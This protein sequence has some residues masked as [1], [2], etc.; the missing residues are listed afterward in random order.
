MA[1]TCEVESAVGFQERIH[2]IG[3]GVD[4]RAD[5]LWRS[6]LIPEVITEPD[7]RT[8]DP[9]WPIVYEVQ[10]LSIMGN[11]RMSIIMIGIVVFEGDQYAPFVLSELTLHHFAEINAQVKIAVLAL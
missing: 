9:A 2:L 1:I 3:R 10:P 7:I 6:P 5:V 11:E 4:L 8:T